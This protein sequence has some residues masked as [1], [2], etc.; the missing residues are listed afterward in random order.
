[1]GKETAA[2]AVVAADF[3]SVEGAGGFSLICRFVTGLFWPA[4]AADAEGAASFLC[5]CVCVCVC[6][7]VHACVGVSFKHMF[8][9]INTSDVMTK[10][11]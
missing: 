2:S 9:L 3:C 1:M 6:V 8:I 4:A 7:C 5:L 11:C 10:F